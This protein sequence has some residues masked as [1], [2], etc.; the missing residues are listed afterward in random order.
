MS[1]F[2]ARRCA[3]KEDF[4][5]AV[6]RASIGQRGESVHLDNKTKSTP[7]TI[8]DK[9]ELAKHIAGMANR[10]GGF[11]VYG[12]ENATGRRIGICKEAFEW[13][14]EPAN[15]TQYFGNYFEPAKD[16]LLVFA[17]VEGDGLYVVICVPR[18][19]FELHMAKKDGKWSF[20]R[21][22]GQAIE[23]PV[24]R[25]GDIPYRGSGQTAPITPSQLNQVLEAMRAERGK[26]ILGEL[27]GV[28]ERPVRSPGRI[29]APGDPAYESALPV[30]VVAAGAD[31]E[32]SVGID[33]TT[34]HDTHTQIVYQHEMWLKHEEAPER[35]MVYRWYAQRESIQVTP[36]QLDFLLLAALWR[37]ALPFYWAGRLDD[38]TCERCCLLAKE[39]GH[40]DLHARRTAHKV[41]MD[42]FPARYSGTE[43]RGRED[44]SYAPVRLDEYMR[45]ARPRVKTQTKRLEFNLRAPERVLQQNLSDLLQVILEE[46][47]NH[48]AKVAARAIDYRLY[49]R[50]PD[51][52]L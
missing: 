11:L 17:L 52:L 46:P 34:A 47:S 27:K 14:G 26:Q 49:G 19:H 35:D 43:Y 9:L 23:R 16:D 41:L 4:T 36:E 48:P 12:V 22:D 25:K 28:V 44:T 15:V 38:R 13:L 6:A 37:N 51:R 45:S 21:E 29:A 39:E 31:A 3:E 2:N 30:R 40:H 18:S 33:A 42:R 1:V 50:S 24:F 10:A 32:S 8:E 7:M 20:R 5:E